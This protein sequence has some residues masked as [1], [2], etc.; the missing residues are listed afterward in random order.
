MGGYGGGRQ[1]GANLTEDYLA[2]DARRWQRKGLLVAGN[3]FNA[4]WLRGGES[5]GSIGVNIEAGQL[6]L[7][8]NCKKQGEEWERLDYP[9]RLQTTPCHYGGVRYWFTCPAGGCGKRVAILYLGDKRFACRKCYRLAYRCQR[10]MKHDRMIRKAEKLKVKLQ[11]QLGLYETDGEKPKGMH[12]KTFRRLQAEYDALIIIGLN[13]K[14]AALEKRV[15][16]LGWL[17]K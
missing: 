9:I 10:E 15:R 8:Y 7:A 1:F 5:I 12:G 3:S 16:H 2:I 14:L 17:D 4:S 13:D 6:Q 11:W